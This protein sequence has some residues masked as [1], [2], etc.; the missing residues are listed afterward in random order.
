VFLALFSQTLAAAGS[1][2][3]IH[4]HVLF[5]A[6]AAVSAA[7]GLLSTVI[8]FAVTAMV[9]AKQGILISWITW[10]LF[11]RSHG[12]HGSCLTDGMD[13]MDIF[14][15]IFRITWILFNRSH[16]ACSICHISVVS[17]VGWWFELLYLCSVLTRWQQQ[18]A[19]QPYMCMLCLEQ[20]LL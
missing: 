17:L 9:R 15:K 2:K 18:V 16:G 1:Q 13:H 12:S 20:L 7:A 10:I 4:V 3:A 8:S 6:A 14:K 5:R 11:N 19:M